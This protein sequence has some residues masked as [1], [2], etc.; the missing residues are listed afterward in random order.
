MKL[1]RSHEEWR[2]QSVGDD[3]SEMACEGFDADDGRR[4]EGER[5][6][7]WAK[8]IQQ[9]GVSNS[10]ERVDRVTVVGDAEKTGCG[11][12]WR[13]WKA[14]DPVEVVMSGPAELERGS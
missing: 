9:P 7:R 10:G 2:K 14:N 4:E 5:G 1:K 8:R 6:G 13:G 11:P 3:R 12:G